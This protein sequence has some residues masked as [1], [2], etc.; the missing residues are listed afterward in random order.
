MRCDPKPVAWRELLAGGKVGMPECEFA[1]NPAAMGDGDDA[2]GLLRGTHLEFDP[3]VD[4]VDR[5][6]QP[7]FHGRE[8][9]NAG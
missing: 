9:Q 4:V 7:W 8:L 1:D 5:G 3:T 2:A 6:L